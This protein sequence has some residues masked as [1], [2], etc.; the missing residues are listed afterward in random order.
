MEIKKSKIMLALCGLIFVMI[1]C[2]GK[3]IVPSQPQA[4]G[5]TVPEPPQGVEN[6]PSPDPSGI[7]PNLPPETPAVGV[8]VWAVNINNGQTAA[9]LLYSSDEPLLLV[10]LSPDGRYWLFEKIPDQVRGAPRGFSYLLDRNTGVLTEG[11]QV[12]IHPAKVIWSGRGFWVNALL[13]LSLDLQVEEYAALRESIGLTK[14]RRLLAASFTANGTKVALVVHDQQLNPSEA[15][16]DLIWADAQG[17]ILARADRSVQP[18]GFFGKSGP[19][20]DLAVSPDGDLLVLVSASPGLALIETAALER[21]QW[22]PLSRPF[23]PPV[24]LKDSFAWPT[25]LIWAPD[26]GHIFVP[27]GGIFE[28]SGREA[29]ALLEASPHKAVWR[30]DNTGVVIT[31]SGA[32]AKLRLVTI[33]GTGHSFIFPAQAKGFLPDGRL[34]M[35]RTIFP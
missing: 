3:P 25:G 14:E 32:A 30:P 23:K 28:R 27:S 12:D 15:T 26:G 29:V 20:V 5:L 6:P 2:A 31:E 13:H 34:L 24:P 22:R 16:A 18:M 11:P 9:E 21:E 19:L 8:Q 1:G 10:G 33:D 4:P 17:H 35:T 7:S